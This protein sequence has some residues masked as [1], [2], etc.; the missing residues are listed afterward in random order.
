VSRAQ[1]AL[2]LGEH[3]LAHG[4][5]VRVPPGGFARGGEAVTG[6]ERVRVRGAQR[7]P[8]DIDHRPPVGDGGFGQ[9]GVVQAPA[10]P[11]QDRVALRGPEQHPG[12]LAELGRAVAERLIE[13]GRHGPQRPGLEHG[14][15]GG[16]G[17]LVALG[18][19][20]A[21]PDGLLDQLVNAAPCGRHCWCRW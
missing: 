6:E 11:H 8:A 19:G 16:P 4:D 10:G 13:R 20:E 17:G 14:V 7:R 5:R 15:G 9:P 1:A 12:Y 3:P 21:L 2:A 18:G